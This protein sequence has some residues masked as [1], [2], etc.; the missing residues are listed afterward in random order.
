MQIVLQWEDIGVSHKPIE[1][2]VQRSGAYTGPFS[3]IAGPITD[4]N[5]YSDTTIQRN[6]T[7]YYR[8]RIIK[9]DVEAFLPPSG[10]LTVAPTET[11]L[12][13]E[14]RYRI[15]QDLYRLQDLILYYPVK[16]SGQ[17]C[18]CYD[19]IRGRRNSKCLSCF[20]TGFV[21]G[22]Y[23]PIVLPAKR[24]AKQEG[25]FKDLDR[26]KSG[27]IQAYL[28]GIFIAHK[29]DVI[30]DNTNSRFA[31]ADVTVFRAFGSVVKQLIMATSIPVD[32]LLYQLPVDLKLLARPYQLVK[33][34][35][36]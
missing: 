23:N 30:I 20:G 28:P 3:E 21:G 34:R 27:A 33:R 29:D 12:T 8:L 25:L 9:D 18:S 13:E 10:G 17:R 1:I 22:F 14:I 32:S 31:V 7:P 36:T 5:V 26:E 24:T 19:S 15:Y 16:S 4:T 11:R 6:T 2:Y 35:V